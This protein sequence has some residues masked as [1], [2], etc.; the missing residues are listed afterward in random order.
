VGAAVIANRTLARPGLKVGNTPYYL[1]LII[2]SAFTIGLMSWVVLSSFK[3]N[4]EIFASPWALP[5]DPIGAAIANYANA[6]GRSH[7]GTYL[8]NSVI[9]SA[10]SIALILVLGTPAAYILARVPFKMRWG[11][12]YYL[13][14]GMGLP[15]QLIGIPLIVEMSDFKL[16]N[17]L[18]GLIL[19]YSALAMPFTILLLTSY[20]KTLSRELEEAAQ[21]DG[22]SRLQTFLRIMV[23]SAMPG[24]FTAAILNFTDVWNEFFLVLL[25]VRDTDVK[26]MPLGVY[27]MKASMTITGDWSSLFAGIVIVILPA[28]F[29]FV[30]VSDRMMTGLSLAA[31]K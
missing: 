31:G 28:T 7:V 5:S 6:W 2:W 26:T 25:L 14:A 18:Q 8:V 13:I 3:T 29:I 17:T 20:F 22:A 27:A 11:V 1:V 12:N 4:Q 24:I 10:G 30:L 9:V 16:I 21:L 23:P 19:V 15:V